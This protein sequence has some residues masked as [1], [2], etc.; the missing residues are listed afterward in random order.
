MLAQGK[1]SMDHQRR[2]VY[3]RLVRGGLQASHQMPAKHHPDRRFCLW[4]ILRRHTQ[5]FYLCRGRVSWQCET[6]SWPLLH[7]CIAR[8]AR[9]GHRRCFISGSQK[10]GKEKRRKEALHLRPLCCRNTG[11][12]SKDG[13][14]WC[15]R[16]RPASCRGRAV[17]PPVRVY[18][19]RH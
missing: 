4:G 13:L 7:P 2:A 14:R 9:S 10:L 8:S 12:L 16:V 19:I 11:I 3:R 6:V 18:F 1:R 5:R 17:W 15:L